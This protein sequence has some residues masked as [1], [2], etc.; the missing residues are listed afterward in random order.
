M[1]IFSNSTRRQIACVTALVTNGN[2][3]S[4]P[5][6]I[7]LILAGFAIV[8]CLASFIATISGNGIINS[9]V[10][11]AHSLSVYTVFS[12]YH[13]IYFTGA[14]SV[15]FPSVLIAFWSN[16]AWAS[17]IITNESMQNSLDKFTRK[18]ARSTSTGPDTEA[19]KLSK[20][21]YSISKRSFRFGE[22]QK[23]GLPVPGNFSGFPATLAE[24]EITSTNA[25][26]TAFVWFL[27]LLMGITILISVFKFTLETLT[28]MGLRKTRLQVFRD[29]WLAF[30]RS[31]LL[32]TV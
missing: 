16:F 11:Y 18:S 31:V 17:G 21:L 13:S 15:N 1:R 32:R 27:V 5:K 6:I 20:E 2:S 7:S 8:V 25:F 26:M 30:L 3:F 29:N 12:C 23:E 24:A 28:V 10:L 19:L 9:R 4:H 14:L 22:H